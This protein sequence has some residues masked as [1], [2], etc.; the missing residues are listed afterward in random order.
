MSQLKEWG[1]SNVHLENWDTKTT[2]GRGG[3]SSIPSWEIKEYSGAMVEPSIFSSSG[4]RN[5]PTVSIA[6]RAATTNG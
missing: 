3:A 1:M 4:P 5:A 6:I 2:G